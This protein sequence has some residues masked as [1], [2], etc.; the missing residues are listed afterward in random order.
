LILSH[1]PSNSL[2]NGRSNLNNVNCTEDRV[3]QVD[4][5]S[6]DHPKSISMSESLSFTEREELI[7]L[8]WEYIDV[9]V[10]NY[11]DMPDLDLQIAIHQLNIKPD[12]K[13]VKQQNVDFDLTS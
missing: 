3:I 5:G 7:G 8:M 11:K 1:G 13:P 2:S 4:V 6:R 12:V 9:F 10:W